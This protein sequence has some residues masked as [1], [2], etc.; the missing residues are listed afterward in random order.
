MSDNKFDF[1]GELQALAAKMQLAQSATPFDVTLETMTNEL[2][3]VREIQDDAI[4]D[5]EFWI[6]RKQYD[7][8]VKVRKENADELIRELER[9]KKSVL[10]AYDFEQNELIDLNNSFWE[11]KQPAA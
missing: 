8:F 7:K 10:Q 11:G 1:L 6:L 4:F 9:L 2:A 5:K 3:S